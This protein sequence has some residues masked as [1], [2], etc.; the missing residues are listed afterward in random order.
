MIHS[1]Q[2]NLGLDQLP[3]LANGTFWVDPNQGHR[4]DSFKVECN[5]QKNFT[6]TCINMN[7][8]NQGQRENYDKLYS[9]SQFNFLFWHALYV[10]QDFYFLCDINSSDKTKDSLVFESHENA[11]LTEEEIVNFLNSC[12]DSHSTSDTGEKRASLTTQDLQ[13]IKDKAA[14]IRPDETD[15]RVFQILGEPLEN[16][17][18]IKHKYIKVKL[19]TNRSRRLPVRRIYDNLSKNKI[20]SGKITSRICFIEEYEFYSAASADQDATQHQSQ[21]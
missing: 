7:Y 11:K 4:G 6:S 14:L 12:V 1:D 3:K 8:N 18:G 9:M 2:E 16:H 21:D 20:L 10:E 5:F 13:D 19:K 15:P 17:Q